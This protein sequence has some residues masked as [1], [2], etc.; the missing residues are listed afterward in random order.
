M[1]E[2]VDK[3]REPHPTRATKRPNLVRDV[4]AQ[5]R[6]HIRN[7][8]L[9]P[10]DSLPSEGALAD[11]LNVSRAV[12]REANRELFAIG[13]IEIM[14]GRPAR[15]AAPK[16]DVL[17]IL[18][19]HAVCIDHMSIQQILDVRRTIERRTAALAALRRTEREAEQITLHARNMRNARDNGAD[20]MEADIAFHKAIADASRNPLFALL[21]GAF[22]TLMEQT[23]PIGW[24]ARED[25]AGRD[26]MF[27][28]HDA[29]AGAIM[30]RDPKHAQIAME[31][32]FDNTVKSLFSAGIL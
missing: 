25:D 8:G 26:K 27:D 12:I 32:H 23:W 3:Q 5:I 30:A 13:L 14:N 7:Q 29:V 18:L 22:A 19:D 6:N 24:A 16:P 21:V 2:A 4:S 10:G 15:V 11:E 31:E 1:V 17:G 9:R 20:V 28:L